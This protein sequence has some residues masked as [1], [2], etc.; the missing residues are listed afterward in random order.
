MNIKS[1]TKKYK[2]AIA[3]A[4]A[5]RRQVVAISIVMAALLLSFFIFS[6]KKEL[7]DVKESDSVARQEKLPPKFSRITFFHTVKPICT[8]AI[9][10]YWEGRYRLQDNN[11]IARF[12]YIQEV[13]N[14]ELFYVKRYGKNKDE[15]PHFTGDGW[16]DDKNERRIEES[17]D[18]IYVVGL[19]TGNVDKLV[20]E[21]GFEK[22]T[23]DLDE[24]L[25]SFKCF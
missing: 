7:K 21:E 3:K 17:K 4:L 24:I 8:L 20:H 12:L 22:M 1:L 2:P 13:G 25:K 14:P 18:N 6:H 9:P 19:S 16:S 5:R 23:T 10:D 11:G 15:Y